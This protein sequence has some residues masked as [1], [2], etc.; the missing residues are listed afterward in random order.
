LP[1]QIPGI[2]L[3]KLITSPKILTIIQAR[4][5]STRLPGKVLLSLADKPL[6][7]RMY[8]RVT[9]SKYAG[10]IVIAITKDELTISY[11]NSVSKIK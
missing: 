3:F 8:E 7:L 4:I 9:F 2:N 6:I 11:L 1:G 5:G 10:E